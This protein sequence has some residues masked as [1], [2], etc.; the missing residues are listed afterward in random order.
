M[1]DPA[2]SRIAGLLEALLVQ[3]REARDIHVQQSDRH[4]R[5]L[6]AQHACTRKV[7]RWFGA[8]ILA[9]GAIAAFAVA[10]PAL[11]WLLSG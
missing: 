10:W 4:A 3:Q 9:F 11:A 7:V 2:D 6:A 1:S 5:D 8:F